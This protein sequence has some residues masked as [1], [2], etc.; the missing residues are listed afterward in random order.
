MSL[1]LIPQLSQAIYKI[2]KKFFIE[3]KYTN[4]SG[5]SNS[6]LF[7]DYTHTKIMIIFTL[8]LYFLRHQNDVVMQPDGHSLKQLLSCR[9]ISFGHFFLSNHKDFN[10]LINKVV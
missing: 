1:F 3:K 6:D 5:Q 9:N 7:A 10:C 4:N 8:T 2:E